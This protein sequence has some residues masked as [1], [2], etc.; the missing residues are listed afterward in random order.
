MPVCA[1]VCVT[2]PYVYMLSQRKFF[3]RYHR[4]GLH[5][6]IRCCFAGRWCGPLNGADRFLQSSTSPGTSSGKTHMD[7]HIFCFSEAPRLMRQ[8]NRG[9]RKNDRE[10]AGV[11]GLPTVSAHVHLLTLPA[12]SRG[13]LLYSDREHF[14]TVTIIAISTKRIEYQLGGMMHT[15]LFQ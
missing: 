9:E 13:D 2:V 15:Y 5:R 11:H 3:W 6:L 4:P 7:L 14:L 12:L 8:G 10:R 1:R